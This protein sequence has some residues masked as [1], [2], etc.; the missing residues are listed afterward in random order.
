MTESAYKAAGVDI[1][2]GNKAVELMEE[3]VRSTYGPEV[4]RGIGAFGGLYHAGGVKGL[5]DPVLVA[6][7]DGVGTKTIVASAMNSYETLGWDIVNHCID[8]ILVQGAE[9][10]FFLDYIAAPHLDPQRIATIV[11]GVAAAC[12]EADCAILGGET[13]EMPDVYAPGQMDLV[14]TIVGLVERGE[15]IDGSTIT[16]GDVLVGVPSNGL[17]TNG[18][19]LVRSIFDTA[20]YEEYD[21]DLGCTLGEALVRPHRSYLP[22]VRALRQVVHVKGLAHITGGGFVD[23]IPRILPAGTRA[24]VDRGA[25]QVPPLFQRIEEAGDVDHDE[26]YHVFNMGIGLVVVVAADEV[27]AAL[28]AVE[29]ACVMGHIVDATSEVRVELT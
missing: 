11:A 16:P 3:A 8:D 22:H 2:A 5:E 13:A 14:G 12:R 25:W 26:M 29:E 20:D 17:H 1:E 18:F 19:S 10:L 15:I 23:N 27:E 9:P 21:E 24:I 7:T 6:S 28:G 4:L